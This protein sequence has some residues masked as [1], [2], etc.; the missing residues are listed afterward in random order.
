MQF[1]I[2]LIKFMSFYTSVSDRSLSN[3]AIR[4]TLPPKDYTSVS[5]GASWH[6]LEND[7]QEAYVLN[8]VHWC[9][10]ILLR[11]LVSLEAIHDC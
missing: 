10:S 1:F 5:L 6:I 9:K 8:H 4:V 7:V 11:I 3:K 2:S